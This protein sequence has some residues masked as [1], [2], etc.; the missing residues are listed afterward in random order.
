MNTIQDQIELRLCNLLNRPVRI[1]GWGRTDAGVHASGAVFTVDLSGREV[2]RIAGL[3]RNRCSSGH[4]NGDGT[5]G[6]SMSKMNSTS[7]EMREAEEDEDEDDGGIRIPKVKLSKKEKT[8]QKKKLAKLKLKEMNNKEK[9]AQTQTQ[10]TAPSPSPSKD[11]ML[12]SAASTLLSTL[13]LFSHRPGSITA[14]SVTSLSLSTLSTH[15]TIERF[16]ARFSCQWKR[17]VY[18]ISHGCGGG[19]SLNPFLARYAWQI[20]PPLSMN[21]NSDTS[22]GEYGNVNDSSM[23]RAVALLNGRHNFE[24]LSVVEPGETRDPIRTLVLSVEEIAT[25][26][27]SMFSMHNSGSGS[28]LIKVSATCDFFLYRMVRRIVGVLLS[29]GTGRVDASVLE[30]CIRFHDASL[31]IGTNGDVDGDS[32]AVISAE[33]GGGHDD[34]PTNVVDTNSQSKQLPKKKRE[35]NSY[36]I[37]EGLLQTAPA[38]GLCL[39]HVEYD[40]P[41]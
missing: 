35:D 12:Q 19:G 33:S 17:Y 25:G 13:R 31:G 34:V 30:S 2:M 8:K 37:P 29:V 1:L 23:M 24:W 16:D 39:E 40:I 20:D 15:D 32:S 22:K 7:N 4:R 6:K 14:H 21:A 41:I 10:Q 27:G 3:H 36:E 38:R 18:Y 9:Q 26:S 28:R 11:S 5:M